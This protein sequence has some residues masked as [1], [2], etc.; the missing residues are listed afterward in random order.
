MTSE[1]VSIPKAKI[2]KIL[3]KL[4]EATEILRGEQE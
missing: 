2:N 3:E 4:E 1:T